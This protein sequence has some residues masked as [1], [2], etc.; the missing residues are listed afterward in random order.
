MHGT[1]IGC[2]DWRNTWL[3][4]IRLKRLSSG[5]MLV[6]MCGYSAARFGT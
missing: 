3:C 2:I 4:I 6:H 1:H 5:F